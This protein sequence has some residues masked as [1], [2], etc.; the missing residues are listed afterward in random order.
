MS[1]LLISSTQIKLCLIDKYI[2]GANTK[3]W[4]KEKRNYM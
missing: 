4:I 3:S 1:S 2:L